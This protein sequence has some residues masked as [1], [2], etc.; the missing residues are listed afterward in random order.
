MSRKLFLMITASLSVIFLLGGLLFENTAHAKNT[1]IH[2]HVKG[3]AEL[4]ESLSVI[5]KGE[6]LVLEPKS[7]T[8]FSVKKPE[9]IVK[10]DVTAIVV[11]KT[12]GT[13]VEYSPAIDYAGEEG[14][15]TINYWIDVKSEVAEEEESKGEAPEEETSADNESD[16]STNTGGTTEDNPTSG[17]ATDSETGVENQENDD[18]STPTTENG[19]ELPD[20]SSPWFNYLLLSAIVAI[21]A[22]GALLALRKTAK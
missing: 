17:E 5:F 13:S 11:Y 20:T 18:S 15:G 9:D 8:L 7:P 10:P 3:D 2:V 14:N 6:E 4:V 1:S 12:D 21:C 19:G 22:G 16:D